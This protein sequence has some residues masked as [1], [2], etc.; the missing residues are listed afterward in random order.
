MPFTFAMIGRAIAEFEM[1]MTFANAPLDQFA[2][3][4]RDA[5]T[6][7]QKRGALLFFGAA[8]CVGCHRVDGSSNEMFSDVANHA[9][10]VPQLAPLFGVGTGDVVCDG[11]Q[12][13]ED[14][15]A[16]QVTGDPRDRYRFRTSPL[17]NVAVQPAFF[18]G[19]A[20]THLDGDSRNWLSV[21]PGLAAVLAGSPVAFQ[22]A[23]ACWYGGGCWCAARW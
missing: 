7:A 5:M 10:G 8:N 1:S 19:G 14:F 3:G 21:P 9:L 6:R 2:R 17:R 20:F 4:D 18:H 12:N 11:P 22:E 15:G 23:D 16:E 13:N